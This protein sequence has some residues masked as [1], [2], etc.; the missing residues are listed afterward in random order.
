MNVKGLVI[1]VLLLG[2]IG[3]ASYFA[4]TR[5]KP[6]EE[7]MGYTA[8]LT[9]TN[10]ACRKK[11]FPQRIIAGERPPYKCKHCEKKTAYRTVRCDNC[12]AIFPDIIRQ[13][14]TRLGT[15]E[16]RSSECPECEYD[17]STLI[18]SM[19]EVKEPPPKEE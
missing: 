18:R 3:V 15:E 11:P 12:D 19:K 1:I 2:V 14:V 7:G 8:I 5:S 4:T 9:C 10:P 13:V 6:D 16:D 17:R